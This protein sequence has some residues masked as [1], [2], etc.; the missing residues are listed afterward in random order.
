[1][2]QMSLKEQI[3]TCFVSMCMIIDNN[4]HL[5]HI[6]SCDTG[7]SEYFIPLRYRYRQ[8]RYRQYRYRWYRY[9]PRAWYR[10]RRQKWYRYIS[11][12]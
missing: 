5:R 9:R 4:S 7:I 8:Y 3:Y 1:M 11:T 6:S 12:L 10:Y 2:T